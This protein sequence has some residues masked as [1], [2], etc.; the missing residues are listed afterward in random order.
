MA[1]EQLNI[2]RLRIAAKGVDRHPEYGRDP[3]APKLA[4]V[5]DADQWDNGMYMIGQVAAL[6]RAV[7]TLA[8]LHRDVSDGSTEL[9]RALPAPEPAAL[10]APPPADVAIIGMACILPGAPD[11]RSLWANILA[12]VDA[13]TEVPQRRWDWTQ[14][15]DP[16]PS[17]RDK[18]YSRWGG[19]IGPV[20]FDPIAFGMPPRSLSSI[21]PFQLL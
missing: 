6:R 4:A 19:F 9:L 20:S 5:P 13:I 14:M 17:A 15:Y 2:G 10:A 12:K 7:V 18:V 3:E 1:L 21:E 11:P 16:D 8:D